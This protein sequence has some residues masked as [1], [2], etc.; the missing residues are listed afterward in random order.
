MGL[1][2]TDRSA[3]IDVQRQL[4]G[5][6]TSLAAKAGLNHIAKVLP[7]C[8]LGQALAVLVLNGNGSRSSRPWA[9]CG[10]GWV[11]GRRTSRGPTLWPRSV[12]LRFDRRVWL[13]PRVRANAHSRWAEDA[14]NGDRFSRGG[15]LLSGVG[16]GAHFDEGR[17]GPHQRDGVRRGL[18]PAPRARPCLFP[19][20]HPR[21]AFGSGEAS[22]PGRLGASCER[23]R[24][25]LDAWAR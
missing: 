15:E 17:A 7:R 22:P 1:E 8:R 9:S 25:S 23:Y 19:P 13:A 21:E 4:R 24:V 10:S 11:S 12:F 6:A 3:T 18:D 20:S 14:S 16:V 5:F 2:P